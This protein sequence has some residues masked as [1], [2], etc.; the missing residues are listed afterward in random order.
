VLRDGSLEVSTIDPA[1][2]ARAL[3]SLARRVSVRITEIAPADESME[4]VFRYLVES[5]P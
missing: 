5:A 2:L 1:T 4:S 3:P